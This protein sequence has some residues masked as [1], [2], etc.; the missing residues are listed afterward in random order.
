MYGFVCR[1][2][3][4]VLALLNHSS[5]RHET[6]G[7]YSVYSQESFGQ[8]P[9]GR[10]EKHEYSRPNCNVTE[11]HTIAV[12]KHVMKSKADPMLKD[13]GKRYQGSGVHVSGVRVLL[14]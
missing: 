5:D 8:M 7:S 13:L 11:L 1:F 10:G 12:S 9:F 3:L 14:S 6:L 2:V 4:Y